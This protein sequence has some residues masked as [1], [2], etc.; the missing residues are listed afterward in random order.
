MIIVLQTKFQTVHVVLVLNVFAYRGF[1][2][3]AVVI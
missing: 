1:K 3:Q 2:A